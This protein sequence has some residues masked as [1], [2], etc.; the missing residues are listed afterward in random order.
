MLGDLT[1]KKLF[2]TLIGVSAF[3]IIAQSASAVTLSFGGT[4][5]AGEGEFSSVA[6]V[7]TIDFNS[8][9]APTSGS[10]IYS[11][12]TPGPSIVSGNTPF[13]H[14]NPVNDNT[15]YLTV[16]PLGTTQGTN[17][18]EISF[19]QSIDYFG[20]YW[21]SVDPYNSIS[22]YNDTTLIATFTGNDVPSQKRSSVY[23]NFFADPGEMF[24]RI[25]L[26]SSTTALESDNHAYKFATTVPEPVSTLSLF[27]LGALGVGSLLKRTKKSN[28]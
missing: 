15:P 2:I 3:G 1:V 9:S 23:A 4:P 25:V 11:A 13:H 5:L 7:T 20:L 16:A 28:N 24:N 17:P 27:I 26:K 19:A 10:I 8:G 21:G 18:V 12:P 14:V 22:F 6:G